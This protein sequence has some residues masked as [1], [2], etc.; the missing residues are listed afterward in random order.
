MRLIFAG[1]PEPALPA[2]DAIL[3]S[4]H[5]VVAVVSRPDARRGRGRHIHPSPVA[6]RALE[7]GIEVLRPKGAKDPAFG[8]RLRELR[9]DCCPVVAYGALLPADLLAIPE[10]G[11]INLHF[12]VLPAWRGAAPVQ[13]AIRAGDDITGASTFR[14]VPELDAGPVFGTMTEPIH[15]ADTA[16][17][18]LDRLAVG[19]ARLLLETLAGVES[20]A[21]IPREQEPDGVSFAPKVEPEDAQVDWSR[22]AVA[23]DRLIRSCTPD[24]GAWSTFRN[25]R[26][27]LGPVTPV[28]AGYDAV[29]AGPAGSLRP[30]EIGAAKHEVLVGTGRGDVRLGEVQPKGKRPM[31]A[32]D[33]ARGCRPDASERLG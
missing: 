2:L 13:A 8:E 32:A 28:Q 24:P 25:E 5:E 20:G 21:L 15:P 7:A 26:I 4:S 12:S 31:P 22:P 9:P 1:T 19:G 16:G 6:E 17:D 10:H 14:I 3:A 30:G 18:L 29:L 11:W 33:W 27:K 23:V